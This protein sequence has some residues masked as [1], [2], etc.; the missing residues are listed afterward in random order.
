M[1]FGNLMIAGGATIRISGG[2]EGRELCDKS[3]VLLPVQW[4]REGKGP[5]LYLILQVIY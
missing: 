5:V 3:S 4:G 1:R 2:L